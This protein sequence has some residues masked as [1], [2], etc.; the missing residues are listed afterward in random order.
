MS[1]GAPVAAAVKD[2][3]RS[4]LGLPF[5]ESYGQSELGGFVAMG[6]PT[7]TDPRALTHAGRPLP[8][9]PAWVDPSSEIVLWGKAMLGYRHQPELNET[10]LRDPGLWTGDVGVMDSDG[11]LRVLGRLGHELADGRWPR[12]VDDII[13]A[14]V[15][16]HHAAVVTINN[17]LHGFIQPR[18]GATID[19]EAIVRDA[20]LAAVHVVNAVPR[21]FS[22]KIDRA[23]IV[24]NGIPS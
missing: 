23:A 18:P 8:D 11:Y 5:V 10:V 17:E 19:T 4:Q 14:H 16:I 22:G 2:E 12:D 15:G 3:Y 13:Y 20:S 1:G 21:T 6:D 9:R 7:D 24:R